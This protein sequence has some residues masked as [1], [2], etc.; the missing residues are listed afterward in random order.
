MDNLPKDPPD[1]NNNNP[2]PTFGSGFNPHTN[3]VNPNNPYQPQPPQNPVPEAPQPP[4]YPNHPNL[5]N[6]PNPPEQPHHSIYSDIAQ[7]KP[8]DSHG[9]FIHSD[10]LV[11]PGPQ[12]APASQAMPAQQTQPTSNPSSII[13]SLVETNPKE[14]NKDPDPPIFTIRNPITYIKRWWNKTLAKEGVDFKLGFKIRPITAVLIASIIISGG[15]S[16]GVTAL[17]LKTFF[18]TSSPILHRQIIQQGTIQ[19]SATGGFY[20]TSTD[21]SMWKLKA[22]NLNINFNDQI[23]K[24]VTVTGNMTKENNV[25]E[26]SEVILQAP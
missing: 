10:Y 6:N 20:L 18:P 12:A 9:R 19:K 24:Q 5:P 4:N 1:Q 11:N 25:I 7:H 26:V 17:I 3:P 22:K 13:P 23:G 15:V 21:Q 8:R 2:P 16:S 14:Y